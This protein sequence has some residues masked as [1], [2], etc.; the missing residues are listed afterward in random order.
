MAVVAVCEPR[1]RADFSTL[2][3]RGLVEIGHYEEELCLELGLSYWINHGEMRLDEAVPALLAMRIALIRASG[4]ALDSEPV[5][6]VGV[7]PRVDVVNLAAYLR[8][9]IVRAAAHASSGADVIVEQA[10]GLMSAQDRST[11]RM[12]AG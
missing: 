7:S 1:E 10:L 8:G 2:V 4:L 12:R 6:F 11:F 5:P 9:L 3:L